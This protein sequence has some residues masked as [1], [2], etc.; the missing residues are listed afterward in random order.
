MQVERVESEVV[1]ICDGYVR[2]LCVA[3]GQYSSLCGCAL[4]LI[5]GGFGIV[6]V[7]VQGRE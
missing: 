4:G 6:E 7:D 3:M 1:L 5:L 2:G